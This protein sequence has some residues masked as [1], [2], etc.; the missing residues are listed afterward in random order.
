M[1]FLSRLPRRLAKTMS[2]QQFFSL[3]GQMAVVTGAGQGIGEAVARRL[4]AA[5]ARIAVL[6]L[7]ERNANAVA[8]SISGIGVQ[9]DVANSASIDRA[10][11]EVRRQLG[12][13]D[14]L[15]NNAGILG[16]TAP[17]WEMEEKDL[18]AVYQTNLKSVF[19]FCRAVIGEMLE[20]G[21]GRILNVASISGKEGVPK[22]IPYSIT[23]AAVIALTKAL[24]KEVAARGNIT[25]NSIAPSIIRTK[26]L[27][28]M[29][30]ET[31]DSLV[32]KVPMGREGKVEEV[33]A[34]ILFLA[35]P[36]NR[37]TRGGIVPVYGRS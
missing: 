22:L 24:A 13:I 11:T 6:D 4:H 14:I 29:P 17:L 23:K 26:I 21:Y 7:N 20:R 12:R 33:A 19:L 10:I 27:D 1:I 25:V 15:V 37:V 31:I 16:K 9:C 18:D 32:G 35:S 28:A 34:T 36:D 5:G 8:Q 2:E 3:S 30:Q